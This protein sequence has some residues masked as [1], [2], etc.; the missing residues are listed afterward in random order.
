LEVVFEVG[1]AVVSRWFAGLAP[2]QFLIQKCIEIDKFQKAWKQQ[3]DKASSGFIVFSVIKS[4]SDH[5]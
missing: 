2:W 3:S 5:H 4:I 1:D